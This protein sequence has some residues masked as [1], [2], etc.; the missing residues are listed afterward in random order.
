MMKTKEEVTQPGDVFEETSE[1]LLWFI[2]PCGSCRGRS[3]LK[4]GKKAGVPSPS[5][6]F[7]R[8]TVTLHPS[9]NMVGHWHGWLKNGQWSEC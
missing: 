9:L 1:G 3:F 2:C 5:W 6:D 4:L 8:E 7:D